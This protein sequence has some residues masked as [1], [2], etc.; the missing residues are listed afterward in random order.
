MLDQRYGAEYE[1]TIDNTGNGYGTIFNYFV[2]S[3][4]L[5]A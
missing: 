2:L 4:I 3:R 1:E 5:K